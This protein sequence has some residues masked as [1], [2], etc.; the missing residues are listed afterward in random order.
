MF[1]RHRWKVVMCTNI[2]LHHAELWYTES[3]GFN[4]LSK[5]P[6]AC[7]SMKRTAQTSIGLGVEHV[8]YLSLPITSSLL[9]LQA[10]FAPCFQ[11]FTSNWTILTEKWHW[12]PLLSAKTPQFVYMNSQIHLYDRSSDVNAKVFSL[13]QVIVVPVIKFRTTCVLVLSK[14][15]LWSHQVYGAL[16]PLCSISPHDWWNLFCG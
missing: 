4:H 5:Q 3:F 9:Q 15:D 8:E 13:D 12:K 1:E 7:Y 6:V 16:E 14:Y 10:S 2:A 11:F